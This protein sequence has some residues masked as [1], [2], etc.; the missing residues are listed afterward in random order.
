MEMGLK[1]IQAAHRMAQR[2]ERGMEKAD[3]GIGLEDAEGELD[4]SVVPES[5][6]AAL[7]GQQERASRNIS[8]QSMLSLEDSS[9]YCA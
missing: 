2:K 3:S 5:S 9:S 4:E 8:I 6:R 7:K 1:N